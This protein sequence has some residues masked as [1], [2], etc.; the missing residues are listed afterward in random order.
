M[1]V[2]KRHLIIAVFLLGTTSTALAFNANDFLG[3]WRY[4]KN[5]YIASGTI[6]MVFS[7]G[8]HCVQVAKLS[9]AGITHW[10][11]ATCSWSVDQAVLSVRT[12][13]S[14]TTPKQV[15]TSTSVTID[16]LS[17]E[18]FSISKDSDRQGWTRTER[19]PDEYAIK[20]ALE[21]AAGSSQ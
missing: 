9:I 10:E 12:T 20:L 14:V 4:A 13:A 15:G 1:S 17:S 6:Y 18:A 2:L 16:S 19:V 11:T 8:G 3:T 7:E 21:R 5:A